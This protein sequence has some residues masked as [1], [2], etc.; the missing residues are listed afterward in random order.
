MP[1]VLTP[2]V[3]GVAC[4]LAEPGSRFVALD[5]EDEGRPALLG[6]VEM[7]TLGF[8]VFVAVPVVALDMVT[9]LESSVSVCRSCCY[10]R[11]HDVDYGV[12]AQALVAPVDD[13]ATLLVDARNGWW[14][15]I[16]VEYHYQHDYDA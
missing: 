1:L 15:L 4:E 11:N 10:C 13:H 16:E 14:I 2:L 9:I 12:S 7:V 8:L 6:L 3:T 5:G